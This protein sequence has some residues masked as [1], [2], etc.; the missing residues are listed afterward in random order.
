MT[1]H[2]PAAVTGATWLSVAV[3][4][5]TGLTA[6]LTLVF[7]DELVDAWAAGRTASSA[8]EPPAFV[9][10]AVTMFVVV[11]LLSVVLI[12]FLREGHEWA[13]MVLSALVAL[14]GVGTLAILR[15]S[16]PLL[17]L[18][19]ALAS[20]LVDAAAVVALWHRDT[21]AFCKRRPGDTAVLR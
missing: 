9:P 4:A 15:T 3:V 17:F 6:L 20:L 12:A 5:M 8:V 10:V 21:R 14:V 11:A 2:R 16:P 13:R 1:P 7:D 19:V 18:L